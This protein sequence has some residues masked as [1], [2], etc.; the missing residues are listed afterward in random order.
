MLEAGEKIK[1]LI[2]INIK[3]PKPIL[4]GLEVTID[5]LDKV[6]LLIYVALVLSH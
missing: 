2:I 3:I 4:E 1:R 5:F 6:G